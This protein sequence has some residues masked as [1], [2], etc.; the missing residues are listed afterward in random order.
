MEAGFA[1]HNLAFWRKRRLTLTSPSDPLAFPGPSRDPLAT[2][3]GAPRPAACRPVARPIHRATSLACAPVPPRNTARP[4]LR[5]RCPRVHPPPPAPGPPPA[6]ARR[7]GAARRATGAR[8]GGGC[9]RAVTGQKHTGLRRIRAARSRF[10][11]KIPRFTRFRLRQVRKTRCFWP[12]IRLSARAW[13][14]RDRRLPTACPTARPPPPVPSPQFPQFPQSPQSL[15]R[16]LPGPPPACVLVARPSVHRATP[17]ARAPTLTRRLTESAS[18][19]CPPP[20]A[21]PLV[22]LV[23]KFPAPSRAPASAIL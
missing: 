16:L 9:Q 19:A 10:W 14:Q 4:R 8:R 3:P 5:A 2:P 23:G 6:P 11:P 21:R 18:S 15:A 1:A 13:P 7:P 12:E 22:F 20:R 17:P